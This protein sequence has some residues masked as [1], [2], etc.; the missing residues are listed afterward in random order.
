M[1]VPDQTR[2]MPSLNRAPSQPPSSIRDALFAAASA[3]VLDPLR[4]RIEPSVLLAWEG[5]LDEWT[6]EPE[7]PLFIRKFKDNRGHRIAHSSGRVL[8]PT[9][10]SPA[11]WSISLAY[12]GRCPSLAEV[13]TMLENDEIPV[14]MAISRAEKEGAH[15]RCTRQTLAGPNELGWKVA[16]IEDVGLGYSGAPK[17]VA[18]ASLAAHHKRFLSPSN[19]FLVPKEYA[20]IA[21][22]PEFIEAF[23][24]IR[25]PPNKR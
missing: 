22:T 7:L 25:S 15:Y 2:F 18:I 9:D 20:G 21:E 23:R 6:E 5:L 14:A 17:E 24:G 4:P 1:G 13:R 16:H 11:H 19:I 12:A 3:W 8:V 10:N